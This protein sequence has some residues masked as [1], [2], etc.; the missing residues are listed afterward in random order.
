MKIKYITALLVFISFTSFAQELLTNVTWNIG[1]PVSKMNQYTTDVTYRGFTISGRR[2]LDKYNSV[3]F[4][5]GWNIFDEKS[6]DPIDLAGGENGSGTVSGTQVRSINSFPLLVG[7]HHHYGKKE[8]MRVFIG[9][10][11][12]MYYILQRLDMGVYRIDNDNWH[13]G[14]APEAGIIIPFDGENSGFYLGAR[15]NYAF[16]SGTALG[17]SENNFYSFYE[18]NIGFS[19]SSRWF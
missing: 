7:I 14:M 9:L 12:G 3:G 16:D 10:N 15:Y 17:G 8:D 18:L 4:M 2:F 1:I 19:F 5:T 6:Y 13:F 11:T